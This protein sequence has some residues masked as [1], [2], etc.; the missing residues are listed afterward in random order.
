V[1][2][3][4]E[5]FQPR[6]DLR[7]RLMAVL[8]NLLTVV[9][10]SISF[11]PFDVWPAAYVAL[12]PWVMSLG[13]SRH[14]RWAVISAWGGGLVFYLL[15]LYWLTWITLA[16]YAALVAFL[17]LYWLAA[18]ILVRRALG[19][20]WPMWLV[21]P[22]VWVALEY[23]RSR[24]WSGFPWFLLA[25]TQYLRTRLI[26]VA[27]MAGAY[28][29]SFFVAMVNGAVVDVLC[30]P[31]FVRRRRGEAR[32]SRR[33]VIGAPASALAGAVLLVYG[34]WRISQPRPQEGPTVAVVQHAY[35]VSLQEDYASSRE[36]FESFVAS[37]EQLV[38]EAVDLVIWPETMLPAGVNPEILQMDLEG[39]DHAHLRA[40][41][42]QLLG[43]AAMEA[44][45]SDQDIRAGLGR[46]IQGDDRVY[47]S[48]Q[49][50]LREYADRIADLTQRLGCP[51]LAGGA[52][53]VPREGPLYD[54]EYYVHRNSAMWFDGSPLAQERYDKVQLVPFGEYVPFKLGCPA[55]HRALRRFVPE[56]M[57][58]LDPGSRD[59]TF[60]LRRGSRSWRLVTPICY[61]GVFAPRCRELVAGR[62]G[63]SAELMVNLSNDGWFIRPGRPPRPSTELPQHLAQY[64]FR[65]VE[66]RVPVVRAVNTG[67]SASIDSTGAITAVVRQRVRGRWQ[68][69][70]AVGTLVLDGQALPD[71]RY[72]EGHGPKILVDHRVSRYSLSDDVFAAAVCLAAGV[73][74]AVLLG[75][76][77]RGRLTR[78]I[79]KG[80]R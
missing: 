19:R 27:D 77:W 57:D 44:K 20:G 26:Q 67:I 30:S 61:E 2:P 1:P 10:L 64:C 14:G 74:A 43:T 66:N 6:L 58:Q 31:L 36:I 13:S 71:G 75:A 62:G 34:Q 49:P 56:V 80:W 48:G 22:V 24:L 5:V 53:V 28:G 12:A 16:G 69:G 41:G 50:S 76:G 47:S 55:L 7:R 42:R 79:R 3:P 45:Y 52:A 68:R 40:L 17:S 23:V 18:A 8:L 33:I 29:V 73:L 59:A 32:L 51:L 37:T 4:P 54:Q 39:L 46:L 38:G 63:K 21:L 9:L 70:M 35:P 65:A 15:N 11:A 78:L 60:T 25:H 72:P